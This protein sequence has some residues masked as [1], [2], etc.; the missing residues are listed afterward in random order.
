MIGALLLSPLAHAGVTIHF[1][2]TASSAESVSAILETARSFARQNGWRVE[3]ASAVHGKELRV[4]DEKD[5]PYE[6]RLTGVVLYP[7]E[8]C[9]PIWLQF[10]DDQFFQNY[11]KTQFAGADVH[12][13]I[14]KLF[15]QLKPLLK[16]LRIDDEGEFWLERDRSVLEAHFSKIRDALRQTKREE[17]MLYGPIKLPDGRIVD[18]I[19]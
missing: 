14:I 1:E 17:P 6:G 11:V 16:S 10:G 15:D 4:V 13:E 7:A 8:M 19:R 3:D 18:M 2:G 5:Q 12:I 9:E